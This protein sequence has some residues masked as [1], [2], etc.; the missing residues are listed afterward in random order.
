MAPPLPTFCHADQPAFGWRVSPERVW[1][2]IDVPLAGTDWKVRF[3]QSLAPG[4]LSSVRDVN[5]PL[6]G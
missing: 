5:V 2:L 6:D 3:C 4:P 1:K